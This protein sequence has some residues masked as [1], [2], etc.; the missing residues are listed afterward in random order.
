MQRLCPV[1]DVVVTLRFSLTSS[2][3]ASA[4]RARLGEP[5]PDCFVSYVTSLAATARP[6][7]PPAPRPSPWLPHRGNATAQGTQPFLYRY[8]PSGGEEGGRPRGIKGS[9]HSI[10]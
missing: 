2:S 3:R 9:A 7:P 4:A 8:Q 10:R 1:P 6:R 5:I